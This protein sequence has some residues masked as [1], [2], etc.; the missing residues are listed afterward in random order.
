[1][2]AEVYIFYPILQEKMTKKMPREVIQSP[3]HTTLENPMTEKGILIDSGI[4][5]GMT[6]EEAIP[7][8]QARLE[9][10]KIGHTKSN[11]KLRDWLFARQRYRGEPIPVLKDADGNIIALNESELPLTLPEIENYEPSGTGESPLANVTDWV[12][13]TRDG[14]S[15]TRETN[16][17]PQR[18]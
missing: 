14:K 13:V 11:Y 5:T 7:A 4:Y 12:N 10:K 9:E 17:M 8:M 2:I 1:M 15:Y 18:A 6:S 3:Q 16:T